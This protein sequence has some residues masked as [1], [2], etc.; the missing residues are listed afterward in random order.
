V[1]SPIELI[2]G[3]VSGRIIGSI[4]TLELHD[5]EIRGDPRSESDGR[6]GGKNAWSVGK[7]ENDHVG[8]EHNSDLTPEREGLLFSF[9]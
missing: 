1:P 7:I 3:V 5:Q 9:M 6:R 2:L 8:S 4:T